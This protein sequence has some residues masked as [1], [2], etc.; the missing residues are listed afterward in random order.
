M[1]VDNLKV[2][3]EKL[4]YEKVSNGNNFISGKIGNTNSFSSLPKLCGSPTN[5]SSFKNSF[6]MN[7][8][9]N[10][11]QISFADILERG[12]Q[13]NGYESMLSPENGRKDREPIANETENIHLTT[14]LTTNDRNRYK[15]NEI[16]SQN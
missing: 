15:L 2:Q 1:Q 7:R 3:W 4:K 16:L 14:N 6:S 13:R 9:V 10:N 11:S 12:K 8:V 5:D